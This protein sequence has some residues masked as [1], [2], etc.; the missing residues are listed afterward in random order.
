MRPSRIIVPASRSGNPQKRIP[1]AGSP[2]SRSAGRGGKPLKT[3]SPSRSGNPQKRIPAAGSPGSRSAGRGG[4]PLKTMTPRERESAEADPRRWIRIPLRVRGA[5]SRLPAGGDSAATVPRRRSRE[6]PDHVVD[7]VAL[8]RDPPCLAHEPDELVDLLLGLGHARRPRGRS[9][10]ASRCPAR[11]SR[12]SAG[13]PP[14][15][16]SPS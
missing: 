16:A 3:M 9:S 8:H 12:R 11:R 2:G 10:R 5:R 1:A 13:R 15:S 14:P 7:R 4:K 6:P